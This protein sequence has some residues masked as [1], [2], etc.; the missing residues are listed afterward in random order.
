MYMLPRGAEQG[1]VGI[2]SSQPFSAT[3]PFG[4]A[5]KASFNIDSVSIQ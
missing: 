4:H 1:Q 2:Q 5:G 3:L